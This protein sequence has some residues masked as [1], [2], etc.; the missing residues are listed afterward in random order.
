[1]GLRSDKQ[2]QRA[3]RK[4]QAGRAEEPSVFYNGVPFLPS[5]QRSGLPSSLCLYRMYAC[6][7]SKKKNT[8]LRLPDPI[9]NDL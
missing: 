1:M 4:A 3:T 5:S 7:P 8:L 6:G 9:P 2:A